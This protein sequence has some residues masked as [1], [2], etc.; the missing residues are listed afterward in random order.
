MTNGR[1]PTLPPWRPLPYRSCLRGLAAVA[2][3]PLTLLMI[4]AAPPAQPAQDASGAVPLDRALGLIADARRHFL[5]VDD[6][7]CTL[8]KREVVRGQAQPENIIALKVRNQPFSVHMRWL[9][10][11]PQE[12]QEACYVA[13]QNNGMMRAKAPGLLGAVG[14]VNLDPHDARAM[15]ASRHCITEAGIGHMIDRYAERWEAER[16]QNQTKVRIN[17]YEFNKRRCVRV[18]TSHPNSQAGDYYAFRNVVYFDKETHLPIRSE[19]YDWPKD[20][21]TDGELLESFS[22]VDLQLNVKLEA[23]DFNY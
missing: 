2:L 16:K 6:Y 3:L 1:F 8:V 7:T 12:G 9:K 14:F 17:E 5:K 18:E 21:K 22:F 13:G 11:K 19:S 10:P 23:K 4:Q 15:Q 20:G